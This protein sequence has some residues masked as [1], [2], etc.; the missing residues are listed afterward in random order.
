PPDGHILHVDADALPGG[1]GDTWAD[2]AAS[3][4][5]ALDRAELLNGDTDP[6]N[7]IGEI[8]IAEGTYRPT[9]QSVSGISRTETFRLLSGVSLYGAFAGHETSLDQRLQNPD[10]TWAHETVL[11]GHLL[12]ND[13]PGDESSHDE[14]ADTVA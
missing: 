6:A 5:Q 7:N 9:V 12:G 2:A 10:G 14:N 1:S 3:L 11:S 13:H 8:W 4:Q